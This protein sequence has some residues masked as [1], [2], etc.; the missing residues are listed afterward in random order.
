MTTYTKSL[1]LAAGSLW[2]LS[3]LL[4]GPVLAQQQGGQPRVSCETVC[5]M[6]GRENHPDYPRCASVCR[7][8][9]RALECQTHPQNPQCKG[10]PA[11]P[12]T[13]K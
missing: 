10:P 9:E 1:L 11:P 6:P 5:D 3:L 12:G 4:G 2:T 8:M 13:A 7:E